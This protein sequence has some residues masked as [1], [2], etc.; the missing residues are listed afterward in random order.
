[1]RIP[2]FMVDAFTSRTF[3]GNPA[4]VCPLDAWPG[5][6]LLRR[7][8]AEH[9][10]SETA[11]FVRTAD[12]YHLRWFTPTMEV[13]LC[14]H[15]TLASAFVLWNHLDASDDPLRFSTRCGT[16]SVSKGGDSDSLVMS[17]PALPGKPIADPPRDL[18]K[19]I[20]ARPREI[21]LAGEVSQANYLLIY[22]TPADVAAL[23]PDMALLSRLERTGVIAA[24]PGKDG[25]DY[26]ERYFA[27][28]FGVPEDPATGS[29]QCTLV[30]YWAQRLER[31]RLRGLQTS[32]RGG[33]FECELCD[34]RVLIHGRAVLYLQGAAEIPWG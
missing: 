8:A 15:A 34:D 29:I 10:L 4:A 22:D 16:L 6:D 3:G 12:G 5:D 9:N 33:E 7:I 30:P 28:A 27:P 14:G 2:V 17:F 21:L 19:G 20:G 31:K 26:V 24:A 18:L 23:A 1:M 11:F 13:D 25:V 32:A